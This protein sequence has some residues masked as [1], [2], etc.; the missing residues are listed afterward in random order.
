MFTNV[1]HLTHYPTSEP[2][3]ILGGYLDLA[4]GFS[5]LYSRVSVFIVRVLI[6]DHFHIP[7]KYTVSEPAN[8]PSSGV[9]FLF[10]GPFMVSS[11]KKFLNGVLTTLPQS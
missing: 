1:H 2:I 10:P 7:L 4:I 3:H 8:T 9:A 11:L 5:L 6:S